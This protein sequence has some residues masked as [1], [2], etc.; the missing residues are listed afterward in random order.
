MSNETS[1]VI[2]FDLDHTIGDF[3]VIGM[4]WNFMEK[5][6]LKLNQLD[7]NNVCSLFPDILRYNIVSIIK[8]ICLRKS[9]NNTIKIILYSNNKK[10]L[11]WMKRIVCYLQYKTN[12]TIFYKVIENNNKSYKDLVM[13]AGLP[14]RAKILFIDDYYHSSM[15]SE[16]VI[17]LNIKPYNNYILNN[18]L[19]NEFINSKFFY[20]K[21]PCGNRY[22]IIELFKKYV[23][24]NN[25][26][27]EKK[28]EEKKI[29]IIVSRSIL[30]HIQRFL[31]ENNNSTRKNREPLFIHR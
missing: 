23:E 27:I 29:D 22:K 25:K 31:N 30:N 10:G 12:N 18:I 17:Y 26:N 19:I 9:I 1:K 21:I 4:I 5:I 14:R 20:N 13:K 11:R 2:I 3:F 28:Q 7:F 24:L 16:K 15:E 6:N 8:Y